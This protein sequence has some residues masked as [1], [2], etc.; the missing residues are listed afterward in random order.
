MDGGDEVIKVLHR[1]E[2]VG[3]QGYGRARGPAM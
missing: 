3:G 2:A 1:D